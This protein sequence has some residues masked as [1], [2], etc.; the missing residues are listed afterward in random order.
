MSTEAYRFGD[1]MIETFYRSLC[2]DGTLMLIDNRRKQTTKQH[3]WKAKLFFVANGHRCH[4]NIAKIHKSVSKIR[5]EQCARLS[6]RESD[7]SDIWYREER[8]FITM[9]KIFS[10]T[11]IESLII[12]FLR[13]IG[14][15]LFYRQEMYN[16][17]DFYRLNRKMPKIIVPFLFFF[18]ISVSNSINWCR[19]NHDES[20]D[21]NINATVLCQLICFIFCNLSKNSQLSNVIK[22]STRW[23]SYRECVSSVCEIPT[24]FVFLDCRMC[25]LPICYDTIRYDTGNEQR[26]TLNNPI[27]YWMWNAACVRFQFSR[28]N[29]LVWQWS[30]FFFLLNISTLH[31]Y[32]PYFCTWFARDATTSQT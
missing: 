30:L 18:L 23:V 10:L 16:L 15:L 27:F 28:W 20:K 7:I 31:I 4:I 25:C 11:S 24:C 1:Q 8:L 29:E 17:I 32:W 26:A 12:V 6:V 9:W 5:H 22:L 3:N 21:R 2:F 13:F 19:E 14:F